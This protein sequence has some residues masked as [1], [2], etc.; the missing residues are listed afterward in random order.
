MYGNYP[1]PQMMMYQNRLQR[2]QAQ[3]PQPPIQ[4]PQMYGN[5]QHGGLKGRVVMG[6]DEARAAQVDL[7]GTAH[8]FDCPSEATIYKKSI[9]LNGMPIF[10]TY[11]RVSPQNQPKQSD[12][13]AALQTRVEQLEKRLEGVYANVQSYA[14]N[15]NDAGK[16][17][18]D[19][20]DATAVR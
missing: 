7:D 14:V 15:A 5:V 10:E 6:I 1:D 17:E 11:R 4:P 19:G 16:P 12:V 18:S 20:I 3:Y 8:Y 9:D 2:M 13:I